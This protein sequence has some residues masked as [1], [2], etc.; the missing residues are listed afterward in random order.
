MTRVRSPGSRRPEVLAVIPWVRFPGVF[1]LVVAAGMAWSFRD[2]EPSL[3]LLFW[4]AVAAGLVWLGLSILL[5]RAHVRLRGEDLEVVHRP[6][7]WGRRSV[8]R[9]RIR[10]VRVEAEPTPDGDASA[11]SLEVV[12]V[13]GERVPL[14]WGPTTVDHGAIARAARAISERLG[15]AL[16]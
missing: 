1:P 5:N 2:V 6:L 7:P 8:P 16:E 13:T 3:E 9:H 12:T 14:L 15:A 4:I 10:A 11:W